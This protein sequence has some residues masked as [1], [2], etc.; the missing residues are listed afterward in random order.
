LTE[1]G[2]E[3]PFFHLNQPFDLDYNQFK[4][5]LFRLTG[6]MMKRIHRFD[7]I[8]KLLLVGIACVVMA[9]SVN[10]FPDST[11][12]AEPTATAKPTSVPP[13][14]VPAHTDAYVREQVIASITSK[15]TQALEGYMADSVLVRLEATECCGPLPRMD[16]MSQL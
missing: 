8:K 5:D 6:G 2:A 3:G 7:L 4:V 10:I 11:A 9:C 14:P 13:S 15:N 12:T 1:S 16:A